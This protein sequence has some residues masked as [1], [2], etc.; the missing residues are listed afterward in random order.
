LSYLARP[1]NPADLP[2]LATRLA[3]PS[4]EA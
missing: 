1:P 2:Y 4:C 3:C